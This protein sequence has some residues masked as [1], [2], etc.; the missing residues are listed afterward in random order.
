M[1]LITIS[2]PDLPDRTVDV[3]KLSLKHYQRAGWK[4]TTEKTPPVRR[5]AEK[6]EA[7]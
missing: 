7:A 3:D 1:E 6:K 5:G 4:V 2:H